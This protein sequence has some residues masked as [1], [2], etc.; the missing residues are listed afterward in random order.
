VQEEE[1]SVIFHA[2]EEEQEKKNRLRIS[3][4]A[5]VSHLEFT[6]EKEEEVE[7]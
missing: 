5:S 1:A 7:S 4:A 2:Q 6:Q 3:A